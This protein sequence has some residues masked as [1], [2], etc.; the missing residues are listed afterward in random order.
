MRQRRI[1]RDCGV[2]LFQRGDRSPALE[3]HRAKR[4][5]HPCRRRR[6]SVCHIGA[7]TR[8]DKRDALV[9]L[10]QTTSH[11]LNRRLQG[12]TLVAERAVNGVDQLGQSLDEGVLGLGVG[13]RRPEEN[14]EENESSE[15]SAGQNK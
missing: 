3:I 9:P 1:E 8:L 15:M 12:R 7:K 11:C 5:P 2:E 13:V 6:C 14:A 10:S 4:A